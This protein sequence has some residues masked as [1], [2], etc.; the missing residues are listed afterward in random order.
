M[1]PPLR[2][3]GLVRHSKSAVQ[4]RS[5]TSCSGGFDPQTGTVYIGFVVQTSGF[6]STNDFFQ[7]YLNATSNTS[8]TGGSQST[9]LSG[10]IDYS[11]VV[12]GANGAYFARK[13]GADQ[14][15]TTFNATDGTVHQMV[16][17]ISKSG[18]NGGNFD[19]LAV[20]IDQSSG[21]PDVAL[22][23]ADPDNLTAGSLSSL[24]LFHVR[25][26]A[27]DS[28]DRVYLD[29]LQI[30]TTYAE[31]VPEPTSM[32]SVLIGTAVLAGGVRARGATKWN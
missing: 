14:V 1:L 7:M 11:L 4:G 3:A 18:G 5:T 31:A 32:I 29:N 22:G 25:L 15:P 24:S 16:L 17:R 27:L 2:L 9:S 23:G 13:A 6:D 19:E 26:S 8:G 12:S 20:F 28:G 21:T 10:G 30:A